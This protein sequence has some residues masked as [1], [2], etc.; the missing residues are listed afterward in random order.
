MKNGNEIRGVMPIMYPLTCSSTAGTAF[1]S[2]EVPQK[3]FHTKMPKSQLVFQVFLVKLVSVGSKLGI[4][5]A[6]LAA[7][8]Y[9]TDFQ[10]KRR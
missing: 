4:S 3:P 1:M 8:H 5:K 7:L 9:Q 10:Y 2:S 6:N